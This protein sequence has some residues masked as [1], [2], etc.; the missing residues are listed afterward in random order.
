MKKK[1]VNDRMAIVLSQTSVSTFRS[2]LLQSKA[3]DIASVQI[4]TSCRIMDVEI[5]KYYL[6]IALIFY[7]SLI[8]CYNDMI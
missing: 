6:Q 1:F 2:L 4:L 8:L 7:L 5:L 3:L